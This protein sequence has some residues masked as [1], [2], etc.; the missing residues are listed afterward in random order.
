MIEK[1]IL[2]DGIIQ[3]HMLCG[4]PVKIAIVEPSGNHNVRTLIPLDTEAA[5]GL[6]VHNTGNDAPSATDEMH[7]KYFQDVENADQSY[8]GAHLFVDADSITQV[9]PLNEVAYHAGDGKGDGNRKTVAMEVCESDNY[10]QCEE[11]SKVLAACLLFT[12]PK[13]K[14]FK[15]QDWSGK[16]CP[17]KIIPYWDKYKK[18]VIEMSCDVKQLE[19]W[20]ESIVKEASQNNLISDLNKWLNEVNEPMPAWA[21]LAVAN[22]L[23]KQLKK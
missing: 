15:H 4:I 3:N 2:K 17:R 1:I 18:E 19:P 13:W 11:N 10:I 5:L 20:K 12:F 23:F 8:V 6:T 7:A 14:L 16:Y 21:V 9:L 22:N